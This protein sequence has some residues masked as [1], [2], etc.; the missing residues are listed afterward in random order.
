MS[1]AISQN[2]N[3]RQYTKHIHSLD[4]LMCINPYNRYFVYSENHYNVTFCYNNN[5]YMIIR[6]VY[7]SWYMNFLW[8]YNQMCVFNI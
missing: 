3:I 7:M 5:I 6:N 1:C 8:K 2:I 4:T